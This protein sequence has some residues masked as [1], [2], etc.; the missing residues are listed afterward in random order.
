MSIAEDKIASR[1]ITRRIGLCQGIIDVQVTHKND[2]KGKQYANI[3]LNFFK[4]EK[5]KLEKMQYDKKVIIE[6]ISD[7]RITQTEIIN[8]LIIQ[9]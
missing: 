2:K 9:M 1:K 6:R 5:E 3:L 7:L 4:A 8:Q